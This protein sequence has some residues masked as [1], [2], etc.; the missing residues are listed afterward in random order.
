MTE[1]L[2]SIRDLTVDYETVVPVRAVNNVSIDIHPGE[3]FGLAGESGCGKSTLAY[4][5]TRLLQPPA[6][7]SSGSIDW[8]SADGSET[9]ILTLDGPALRAFRWSEI[10]M[11]FQGAM[12]ALNPVKKVGP[13]IE[14]VFLD[15][16]SGLSRR[17]RH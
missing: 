12:N 14:D 5:V 9:D 16:K 4:A 8:A 7:I 3:I 11:V 1:P 17:E 10:S 6:V 13:Q 15:H 2:L